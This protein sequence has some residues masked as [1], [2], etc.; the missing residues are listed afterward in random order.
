MPAI[1]GYQKSHTNTHPRRRR[2]KTK[3]EEEEEA[4]I[5]IYFKEE[6]VECEKKV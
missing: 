4:S 6:R 1:G 5:C 3:K 2:K